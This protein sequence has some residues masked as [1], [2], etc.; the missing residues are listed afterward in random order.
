[1]PK[2]RAEDIAAGSGKFKAELPISKEEI[3]LV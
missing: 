1:M 2:S 3:E